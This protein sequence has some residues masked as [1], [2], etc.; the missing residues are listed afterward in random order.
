MT[1]LVWTTKSQKLNALLQNHRNHR[2]CAFPNSVSI[3]VKHCIDSSYR[4]TEWYS[5][6][7]YQMST[8][9]IW[10][11]GWHVRLLT[12]KLKLRFSIDSLYLNG[13][14]VLM[15][16]EPWEQPDVSPCTTI[17]QL[18]PC[19]KAKI[20]KSPAESTVPCAAE[21]STTAVLVGPPDG[22]AVR[23]DVGLDAAV[24]ARQLPS[25]H[26]ARGERGD[27][28][29]LKWRFQTEHRFWVRLV[30]SVYTQYCL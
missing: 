23:D 4:G 12:S 30:Q 15:S 18:S 8:K 13:T 6:I 9:S 20:Q 1:I 7:S 5:Y 24:P 22:A 26:A 16:T 28:G 17:Q 10:P 25:G 14:S 21:R 27:L 11:T 29:R 3:S 2:T 19:S